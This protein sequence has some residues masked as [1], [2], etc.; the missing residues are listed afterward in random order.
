MSRA[1]RE[2]RSRDPRQV[3]KRKERRERTGKEIKA[4]FWN[5]AGTAKMKAEDWDYV[6]K[7]DIIGLAETWEEKDRGRKAEVYLKEYV[8]KHKCAVREKKKGRAKGGILLAIRKGVGEEVKWEERTT[9]EAL[10]ARWKKD[11]KTWLW[12]VTYMR[13]SRRENYKVMEE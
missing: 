12:G 6:R 3:D 4:I 8:V 2:R 1:E 9:N 5:V 7:F 11:G 10:V 13:H